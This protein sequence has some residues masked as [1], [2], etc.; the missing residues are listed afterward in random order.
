M[1][2]GVVSVSVWI[3][4]YMCRCEIREL[5]RLMDFV[6]MMG[7]DTLGVYVSYFWWGE[8]GLYFPMGGGG[9]VILTCMYIFVYMRTTAHYIASAPCL[10]H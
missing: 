1:F 8:E 7:S 5:R 9:G 3:S 2:G 6:N 10:N 4:M